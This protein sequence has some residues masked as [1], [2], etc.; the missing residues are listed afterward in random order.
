MQ[1]VSES[2]SS[3]GCFEPVVSD[4]L[5]SAT[6]LG[7]DHPALVPPEVAGVADVE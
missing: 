7:V 2:Q 5:R 6:C 1:S 3:L 4:A